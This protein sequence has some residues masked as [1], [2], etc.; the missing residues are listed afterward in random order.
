MF[1]R[2]W[3]RPWVLP[4]KV[5]KKSLARGLLLK[6]ITPQC[7]FPVFNFLEIQISTR[8]GSAKGEFLHPH[9]TWYT[10]GGV[11]GNSNPSNDYFWREDGSI[12][13]EI[14]IIIGV[15]FFI[16]LLM[17]IYCVT[18]CQMHRRCLWSDT[19]ANPSRT[20]TG[21]S[22]S[23][24]REDVRIS[25]G[26]NDTPPPNYTEV[27]EQKS[28]SVNDSSNLNRYPKV[29]GGKKLETP[30]PAYITLSPFK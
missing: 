14:W 7:C 5:A 19:S 23:G 21:T 24:I 28:M 11:K 16:F 17:C 4:A 2:S 18:A 22:P 9:S 26:D 10:G 27:I 8:V 30:P 1:P 6:A 3:E 20:A 29:V 12:P 13:N 15:V 25:V